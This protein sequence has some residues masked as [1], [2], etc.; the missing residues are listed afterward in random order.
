MNRGLSLAL[1]LAAAACS[2]PAAPPPAPRPPVSGIELAAFDKTVR[3]QDDLFQHVNGGWLKTTEIPADKSSYGAFDILFDKAQADLKNIVEEASKSITKTVG[4]ETQKIGDFYESFMNETLADKLGLSPLDGQLAAIDAIKTKADL[5]RHFGK[6]F[7]LNVINPVVGYVDGDAQQPTHDVLYL[8]QGGL[9][10]PDRD[11]Y[12]KDDPKLKEYREKYVAFLTTILQL[13]GDTAAAKTAGDIFALETRLARAHWTN[14][15]NRDAVKTYNKVTLADLGKQFPGFDWTAWTTEL[16]V[17]GTPAVVVSQP[18]YLKAFAAA[19]NELPVERWRPYL[20]ASLLNGFAP[21]LSKPYVDAEFGFY[22]ITLRGVKEQQPRWKRAVNLLNGNLGEILGKLYVER[23]FKPE[24][25]ARMEGLVENLRAAYKA[26]IDQLEWMGPETRKQAQEKLARF[27]PKIG[28]PG[29]WRDYS[30]LEIRKEDLVGNVMRAFTTES[31]YQLGK[32]GKP[33]DPEQWNMTPQTINAYYNPV[34]NE[35]VFPAAILQPPF[36]N[37]EADD[38]VNYGGIGAIIGHEMG[39]GFDDQ[40]RR[41]DA[42]GALRDWWT[43]Q[44]EAEYQ[45]RAKVLVDQFNEFEPLPGLKV[46]GALTLGENIADLTGLVISHRA[47]QLALKGAQA[48]VVDGL[49]ADERFYIGWAQSWKAKQRDEALRQQVLTNVHS[50]EMYRAN[51]PLRNIPDF[52][53]A[54]GVKEGDR[55]FLPPDRRVKIW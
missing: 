49:P 16:G 38:A 12:L 55:L 39:H 28:Y 54:F 17:N 5:A 46:N 35:I 36:F 23:H 52:H 15:E 34:R 27:R 25:K 47:Y 50:P 10:L 21:Y 3:P 18:S 14:V 4:S 6:L 19:V 51:G 31:N 22:N 40:G 13:A 26:G 48:P 45:K 7:K 37:L 20:R 11:Y 43:K 42:T 41:F 1:C 32:A 30:K 33:I 24:A 9:G 44:D 29:K 53:A 2:S 8:Y